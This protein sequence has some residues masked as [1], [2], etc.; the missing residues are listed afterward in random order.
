MK[1]VTNQSG[2]S[3]VD[4]MVAITILLVGVL[5]LVAAITRGIAMTTVSQEMLGAKQLAAATMESIF[6][7]RELDSIDLG[8]NS[9]GNVGS[10]T[11]PNGIFPVDAQPIYPSAGLDRIFGTA[12]DYKGPDGVAGNGD[13]GTATVGYTRKITV[14]DIPDATRPTAPISLRKLEVTINYWT[15]GRQR[16][17]TFTSFIANYRTEVTLDN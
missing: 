16:A 17:E 6:T 15:S 5:G 12:D 13:D 2:F 11:V 10:S 14:T 1:K 4:V 9:I 8:W 7:A 3:Y